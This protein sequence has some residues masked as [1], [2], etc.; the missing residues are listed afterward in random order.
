MNQ[1]E[2]TLV[3]PEEFEGE[4][5]SGVFLA[6]DDEIH[7]VGRVPLTN[8]GLSQPV[9]EHEQPA[10]KQRFDWR[11]FVITAGWILGAI[12]LALG[13]NGFILGGKSSRHFQIDSFIPQ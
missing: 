13:V 12:C 6:I 9:E 1:D 11:G 3:A 5:L 8:E 7:P 2:K 4:Y 10:V